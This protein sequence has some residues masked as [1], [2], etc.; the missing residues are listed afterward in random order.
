[1]QDL[2]FSRRHTIKKKK[3]HVYTLKNLDQNEAFL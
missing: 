3:I 2:F 1:M